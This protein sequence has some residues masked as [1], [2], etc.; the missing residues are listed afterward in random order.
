MATTNNLKFISHCLW[1][2][3]R[4]HKTSFIFRLA[5]VTVFRVAVSSICFAEVKISKACS[6]DLSFCYCNVFSV[7][8]FHSQ[9]L[10]RFA[11]I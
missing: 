5:R 1:C 9:C 10:W 2:F 6:Q 3:V 11:F 8:M 4:S 7:F